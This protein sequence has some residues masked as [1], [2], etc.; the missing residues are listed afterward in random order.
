VTS[1][2]E[3]DSLARKSG[4]VPAGRSL[5]ESSREPPERTSRFHDRTTARHANRQRRE[6]RRCGG[7][8]RRRCTGHGGPRRSRPGGA[9][10]DAGAGRPGCATPASRTARGGARGWTACAAPATPRRPADGAGDPGSPLWVG[11]I[12]VGPTV[13]P[14]GHLAPGPGPVP[15]DGCT[16]PTSGRGATA[17]GS[18]SRTAAATRIRVVERPRVQ[19]ATGHADLRGRAA[20]PSRLLPVE[21][22]TAAR[23]RR[24]CGTRPRRTPS[25]SGGA[26]RGG[27][28]CSA[29]PDALT[30]TSARRTG[31]E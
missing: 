11:S 31:A 22:A 27:T 14:S 28:A 10:P 5:T 17:A 8:R 6:A 15:T 21:R 29:S 4:P 7:H 12:G 30:H 19:R 13:E 26:T 23:V 9:L 16:R 2:T 18:G 1:P 3:G 20:S 25:R 24:A